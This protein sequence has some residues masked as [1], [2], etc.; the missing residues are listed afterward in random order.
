MAANE[1][2]V[3]SKA[4]QITSGLPNFSRM[5]SGVT[6]NISIWR[7]EGK[8]SSQSIVKHSCPLALNVLLRHSVPE[9]N[10]NTFIPAT[11]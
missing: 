6:S 11:P 8:D 10:S 5:S 1:K 7:E 2:V 9:N 4:A 3:Q